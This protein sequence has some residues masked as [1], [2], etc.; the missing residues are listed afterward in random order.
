MNDTSHSLFHS[1]SLPQS[2]TRHAKIKIGLNY[3]LFRYRPALTTVKHS[4]HFVCWP[5]AGDRDWHRVCVHVWVCMCACVCVCGLPYFP[6]LDGN[7]ARPS[8]VP[9]WQSDSGLNVAI[10][11]RQG[12]LHDFPSFPRPSPLSLLLLLL[13]RIFCLFVCPSWASVGQRRGRG[14]HWDFSI[15]PFLATKWKWHVTYY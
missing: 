13:A 9:D 2:R 1:P 3:G 7:E 6:V 12:R 15:D 14:T 5:I 8:T 10:A 4:I 11:C